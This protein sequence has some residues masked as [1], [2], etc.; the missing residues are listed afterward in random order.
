MDIV[1][2]RPRSL[3]KFRWRDCGGTSVGYP[4]GWQGQDTWAMQPFTDDRNKGAGGRMQAL[5]CQEFPNADPTAVIT[6]GV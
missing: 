6:L 5:D 4:M 1:E 2:E 3:T